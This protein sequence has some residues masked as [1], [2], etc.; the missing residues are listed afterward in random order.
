MA[1]DIVLK[2]TIDSDTSAD[3]TLKAGCKVTFIGNSAKVRGASIYS[4]DNSH[5]IFRGNSSIM[6][7]NNEGG[8][9]ICLHRNSHITFKENSSTVF[10]NNKVELFTLMIIA[11]YHLKETLL[12]YLHIMMPIVMAELYTLITIIYCP[13]KIMLS[14]CLVITMLIWVELYILIIHTYPLK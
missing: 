7:M 14:Q 6:F 3:S 9:V 2:H 12:H 11:L 1:T 5:V 4:F 8:G 13:L 10:S